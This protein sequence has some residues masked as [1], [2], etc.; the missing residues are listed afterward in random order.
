MTKELIEN[1]RKI[2]L[3]YVKK[4]L[5]EANYEGLG[6]LDAKEFEESFNEILDLAIEALD[7]QSF[8]NKSLKLWEEN[9]IKLK[10]YLK[11]IAIC[12]DAVSRTDV[13][14]ALRTCF[15]TD[16]IQDSANGVD[17][18]VYEDAIGEIESLPPVNPLPKE[19]KET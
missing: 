15:D 9:H 19:C 1:F 16:S 11:K 6:E 12:Q 18:I 7:Q 14:D 2:V 5:L 4:Q 8:L 3:P 13:L 10:E 17:Y